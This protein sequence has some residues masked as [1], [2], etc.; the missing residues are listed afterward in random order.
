MTN[1]P[2]DEF[3]H[4]M[5]SENTTEATR[6]EFRRVSE[7]RN[8]SIGL[9]SL[10]AYF[11][12]G[13]DKLSDPLKRKFFLA[14]ERDLQGLDSEAWQ[15]LKGEARPLLKA[16][17]QKRGWQQLFDRLNEAKGYNYLVSVGCRNAKFIPRAK[18]DNMETPDL[19]GLLDE[20]KVFCEVKTINRSDDELKRY[21][22]RGVRKTLRHLDKG[23]F[24]KLTKG[25][26]KAS[27]QL[28]A[29]DGSSAARRIVYVVFN[30]DDLLHELADEY[31][32]Q[33]EA[34]IARA[35]LP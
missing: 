14:L 30:F 10:E 13:D 6:I 16:P 26:E 24:D 28:L 9:H 21:A 7:L 27:S 15:F 19:Q 4:M 35:S 12:A 3:K 33:I 8:L 18:D 20:T 32:G 22:A 31:Q 2:D 34:Y 11:R 29:F 23:F 1:Y 25:I 5:Q 17:H